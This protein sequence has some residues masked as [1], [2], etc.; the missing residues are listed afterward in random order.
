[1]S[2]ERQA[3]PKALISAADARHVSMDISAVISKLANCF[4]EDTTDTLED[5]NE[6]ALD[7]YVLR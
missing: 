7:R 3:S 4:P 1:M 2:K 5:A 6:K